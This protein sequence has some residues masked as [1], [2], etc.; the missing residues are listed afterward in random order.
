MLHQQSA[1]K[2]NSNDS[3]VYIALLYVVFCSAMAIPV[4]ALPG[5]LSILNNEYGGVSTIS[6]VATLY[7]VFSYLV[8]Y[9][10][11]LAPILAAPDGAFDFKAKTEGS[12]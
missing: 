12:I 8:I 4:F 1:F 3:R 7:N 11:A 5:M 10:P 9:S 2:M 6:I